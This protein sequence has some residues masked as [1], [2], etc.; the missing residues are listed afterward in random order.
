MAVLEDGFGAD[1][2]GGWFLRVEVRRGL[3]MSCVE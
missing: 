3:M 1:F 2:A